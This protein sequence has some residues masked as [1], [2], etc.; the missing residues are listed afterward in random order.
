MRQAEPTSRNY[1]ANYRIQEPDD[2][3][4]LCNPLDQETRSPLLGLRGGTDDLQPR[5]TCGCRKSN[6]YILMM[7]PAQYRPTIDVPALSTAR[8]TG[9][10]GAA[11]AG[12][13]KM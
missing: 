6:P 3:K 10:S 1:Q 2:E 11:P 8:G 13:L 12:V 9:A 5:A 7:Q 4:R